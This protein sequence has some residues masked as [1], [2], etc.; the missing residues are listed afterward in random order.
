MNL[1]EKAKSSAGHRWVWIL[2]WAI[3][4][5]VAAGF[6][7]R[8]HRQFSEAIAEAFNQ[9]QGLGVRLIERMVQQHINEAMLL[10]ADVKESIRDS[11]GEGPPD[12]ITSAS[13]IAARR[14][15]QFISLSVIAEDGRVL[16][17]SLPAEK[18]SPLSA[19]RAESRDPENPLT[20]FLSERVFTPAGQSTVFVLVPFRLRGVESGLYYVVGE[21]NIRH[22][23]L[24]VLQ[25]VIGKD[26]GLLIADSQGEVYL[27][28]NVEHDQL[29][30]MEQGN[31]FAVEAKCHACHA[32]GSFDDL[33]QAVSSEGLVPALY[34]TPRGATLNRVSGAIRIL[35]QRWIVSTSVPYEKVQG[36]IAANA[37]DSLVGASIFLVL[38]AA[39]AWGLRG[40]RHRRDVERQNEELRVIDR[41]KDALLRDVAHE[42]KTPVAKHAMQ[43]E[44]LRPMLKA[45]RL[46][47]QEQRAF[48][49]MEESVRRQQSVVRNLL[50]LTRLEA[51]GRV[52]RKEPLSLAAVLR[53]V[54]EDYQYAFETYGITFSLEVPEI[55]LVGD[56]EMLWHVFSNLVNNAIK[57][58]RREGQP[59]IAVRAAI[60]GQ[61]V[62][63]RV[64][65][66]GIGLSSGELEK[67][68]T[69]FYQGTASS[70]GSGVGLSICKRI[71]EDLGGRI[72]MES[73]GQ[74]QGCTA[75]V[76]LP[77]G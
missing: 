41:M 32:V 13:K 48:A 30:L 21:L 77:L 16:F 29:N 9:Q 7:W 10:L 54:H 66:D 17:V 11:A 5:V 19:T 50:N 47:P 74:G 24:S 2:A 70:E 39:A 56:D 40:S 46:A 1:P 20:P 76:E 58:R 62:L 25:T 75:I 3:L 43:L 33:R 59:H 52:Y 67:V 72:R 12:F 73:P 23:M 44:I 31:I 37:R 53:R 69:S 61:R 71:V 6:S 35:N 28:A 42:L 18:A 55:T 45:H 49:A 34:R 57:F 8:S 63:V 65:D 36:Q 14:I 4:S 64:E 22:Y 38:L 68:F 51:G 26:I 15:D 27:I 60:E